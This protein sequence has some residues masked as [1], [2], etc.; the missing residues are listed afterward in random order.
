MVFVVYRRCAAPFRDWP[1][2]DDLRRLDQTD[3]S[4]SPSVLYCCT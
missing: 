4:D 1:D 3:A 2:A